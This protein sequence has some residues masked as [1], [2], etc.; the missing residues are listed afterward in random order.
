MLIKTP[1]P[2]SLP[3]RRPRLHTRKNHDTYNGILHLPQ[4]THVQVTTAHHDDATSTNAVGE[5]DAEPAG[6]SYTITLYYPNDRACEIH[7]SPSDIADLRRALP[8]A[9]VKSR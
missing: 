1:G 5:T 9:A 7:R 3:A 6:R 4:S 8:A 2:R